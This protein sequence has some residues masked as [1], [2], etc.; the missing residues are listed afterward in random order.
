MLTLCERLITYNSVGADSYVMSNICS[1]CTELL[2]LPPKL[3]ILPWV[4]N[5]IKLTRALSFLHPSCHFKLLLQ[6]NNNRVKHSKLLNYLSGS[7]PSCSQ[8]LAL[9]LSCL[10]SFHHGG[11][12]SIC[13]ILSV[14]LL[15]DRQLGWHFIAE[16][17]P[18]ICVMS[19][20]SCMFQA[21]FKRLRKSSSLFQS[22]FFFFFWC[23]C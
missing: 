3:V 17:C 4:I 9:C 10:P 15:I 6:F 16:L 18:C 14:Y 1:W 22:F 20:C 8:P 21:Y 19:F 11:M 7:N 2:C 13:I 12:L 5:Y 23:M